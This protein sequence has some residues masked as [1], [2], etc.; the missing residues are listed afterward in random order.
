MQIVYRA[1]NLSDAHLLRQLMEAEG[2]P[3][4]VQGEFLQGAV[5]E[6]PANTEVFVVA[7]D[8]HVEAARAVVDDWESSE[9]VG[10]EDESLDAV[11]DDEKTP[12][13]VRVV[14]VKRL[15]LFV[16]IAVG[17]AALYMMMLHYAAG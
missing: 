11:G 16:A 6:L 14:A 7:P 13:Q 1:A 17:G 5:G 4:F 10:F 8:E 2:I 3:A 12:A 15:L 9:P